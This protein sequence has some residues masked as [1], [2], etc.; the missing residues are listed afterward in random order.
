VSF[1]DGARAFFGYLTGSPQ[2]Q[3]ASYQAFSV[4]YNRLV[5]AYMRALAV[6]T[7]GLALHR[8]VSGR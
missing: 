7:A 2:L 3:A 1:F 6:S 8:S 4:E 5:A